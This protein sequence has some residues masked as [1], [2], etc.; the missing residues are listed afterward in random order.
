MAGSVNL[1]SKISLD[2]SA[3]VSGMKQ[4]GRATATAAR[5]AGAAF[6]KIGASIGKAAA[7]MKNFALIAGALTFG[8]AIAGAGGRG[9]GAG[10]FAQ[11]HA[12]RPHLS[13]AAPRVGGR[14][15]A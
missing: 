15:G 2:D 1:K 9:A 8:A 11:P 13:L 10:D 3:F 5:K 7:R 6:R 14:A 4:V 12:A